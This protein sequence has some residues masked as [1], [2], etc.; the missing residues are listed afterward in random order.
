[1]APEEVREQRD[2]R[3][4]IFG[5][6]SI[7]LD[8]SYLSVLDTQLDFAGVLLTTTTYPDSPLSHNSDPAEA[9]SLS[10]T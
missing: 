2:Q 8:A 9:G 3:G 4:G 1:M 7:E 6:R 10:A 5:G